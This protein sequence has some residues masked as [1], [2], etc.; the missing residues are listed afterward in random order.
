[1]GHRTLSLDLVD[2]LRKHERVLLRKYG[3]RLRVDKITRDGKS[4]I[5]SIAPVRRPWF[6]ALRSGQELVALA[7]TALVP[8][9]QIGLTPMVTAL[10]K[11][12]KS[13][14]P[15]VDK[16]D[17]F[18]LRSALNDRYTEAIHPSSIVDVPLAVKR[19]G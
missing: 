15:K 9:Y 2:N 10:P 12:P 1:M 8:L 16:N 17:P 19:I 6:R 7:H 5:C 11:Q 4:A 18:G 3:G 14:F 13:S